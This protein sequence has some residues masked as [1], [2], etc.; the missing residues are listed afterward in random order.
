MGSCLHRLPRSAA[1]RFPGRRAGQSAVVCLALIASAS[2]TWA[3][4][5]SIWKIG[6]DGTRLSFSVDQA[7]A[8]RTEG[9]FRRFDGKLSVDFERPSLSFV[10]FR[11]DARSL[12][13]DLVALSA[14]LRGESFL[15]TPRFAEISFSSTAV[16]VVDD[17]HV[18]ITGNL[19]LRG[20]TRPEIVDVEVRR[21]NA[22]SL[23]FTAQAKIDRL[24][25]GLGPDLPMLSRDVHLLVASDA[26][27]Q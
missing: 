16:Q 26:V 20:Q 9:K 10:K 7:G 13:T 23:G 27:A 11:V 8:V 14:L 2:A 5:K 1:R 12:E 22:G 18:R 15:N 6:P 24:D 4:S 3:A 21:N 25:F 17:R 19:T